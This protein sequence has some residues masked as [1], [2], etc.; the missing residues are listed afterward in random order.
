MTVEPCLM[1]FGACIHSRLNRLIFGADDPKTGATKAY[2]DLLNSSSLN[3]KF[4]VTSGVLAK[5]ASLLITDFFREKRS[6]N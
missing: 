5:E 1:C 4:K 3:H 6:K 2:Y